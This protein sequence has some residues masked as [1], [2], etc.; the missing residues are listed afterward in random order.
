MIK[1]YRSSNTTPVLEPFPGYG[2]Q[3]TDGSWRVQVSG[4]AYFPYVPTVRKRWVIRMLGGAMQAS[5]DELESKTFQ[6]RVAKFVSDGTSGL[7]IYCRCD[8]LLRKLNRK[9]KRNGHFRD[10]VW[11]TRELVEKNS[12]VDEYGRPIIRFQIE[13]DQAD[14]K[15]VE[16]FAYLVPNSGVSVISDIDDT[17][18]VSNVGDRRE[19]LANTFLREFKGIE[20]MAELYDHWF[21]KGAE[22]HYVSSSPWQLHAPLLKLQTEEGF[23]GGTI[24]L[25]NF[26]LRQHMVERAL[27][28]R[29]HGKSTTIKSLFRTMP[30]RK[31]VLIGDSGEKDP[32]IYRKI[33]RKYLPQVAGIFFRD[34]PHK[35][36]DQERLDK[37]RAT[38][39]GVTC[40]KFETS[41]ELKSLTESIFE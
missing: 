9:N 30:E 27:L 35:P 33:C 40:E 39:P 20:G 7:E 25:R 16:N 22:F 38:L 14:I 31:F 13:T 34:M 11:M 41:D 4:W 26:R 32:E 12:T 1:F 24:H 3:T 28:I 8:S 18:K 37:C 5:P 36:M 6:D 2:F 10:W 17:I 29:R 19:L 23:P 21:Q 15:P